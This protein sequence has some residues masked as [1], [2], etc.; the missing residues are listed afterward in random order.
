MAAF[1]GSPDTMTEEYSH[2]E[3]SKFYDEIK[4]LEEKK[5]IEYWKMWENEINDYPGNYAL[6]TLTIPVLPNGN[7]CFD[8]DKAGVNRDSAYNPYN[9]EWPN[10]EKIDALENRQE[11]F[12]TF[13]S[14]KH[15]TYIWKCVDQYWYDN[16]LWSDIFHYKPSLEWLKE[17]FS[18]NKQSLGWERWKDKIDS[19]LTYQTNRSDWHNGIDWEIVWTEMYYLATGE[20]TTSYEYKNGDTFYRSQEMFVDFQRPF[21]KFI[22]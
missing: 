5:K 14:N 10:M 21:I 2:I 4:I 15:K 3:Q 19:P 1:L 8:I 11:F 13:W 20:E 9:P 18:L 16:E 7:D 6:I 22:L 12:L 17:T